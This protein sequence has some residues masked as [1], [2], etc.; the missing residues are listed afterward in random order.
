MAGIIYLVATPIGNLKDI[1]MRALEI[2][3]S[4]DIVAA[5]DTRNTIHLLN[6]YGIKASMTSYHE[7]NKIEKA[8]VLVEQALAGKN[9]ALVTDAGMPAVS[10]PGEDL[11]RIA[12]ENGVK[13]SVIPG[14]SASVS[15]LALSG[16][17]TRRFAFEAF[18]PVDK[19]EREMVLEQMKRETRTM[20]LYEAPHR[21]VKTLRLLMQVLGEERKISI[22]REL[23][24]LHEEVLQFRLGEAVKAYEEDGLQPRGEYVL[25][26]EGISNAEY[27]K[28]EQREWES[29][30]IAEHVTFY[31]KKGMDHKEAMRMA[32][33]DRGVSKREIYQALLRE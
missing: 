26:I 25:V 1:T 20:I 2:L 6:Y 27:I 19:K 18:L 31:E 28:E 30:S 5:E 23:T 21:L 32:A 24:K 10:D 13:V 4:A 29:L 9:I 3:K 33:R 15:A 7:Y 14:A 22:V 16:L 12:Y 8:Q 11:V 17:P